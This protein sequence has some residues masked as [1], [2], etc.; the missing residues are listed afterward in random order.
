MP[1]VYTYQLLAEQQLPFKK[2]DKKCR[3]F[4]YSI[5]CV[6]IKLTLRHACGKGGKL[7][8]TERS[9]VANLGT[10]W[11]QI[12]PTTSG[13]TSAVKK[14]LAQTES[15]MTSSGSRMSGAFSSLGHKAGA[16]L[17]AGLV[18]SA[19]AATA[20]TV[21]IVKTAVSE[22]ANY[23]Q[24]VGGVETLFKESAPRLM[25][26]AEDSFKS[27][28]I[29]AN[30]YMET[31]T[32]FSASLIQSL[33]GDTEKAADYAD[34]AIVDMADN[35]NKMGSSL[36]SIQ[37]AYQGF[38]KQNYT[39]LDNLKLGY[40]GTKTE[41]E[42]L[43]ADA[44]K[45]SGVHYE[46]G[47]FADMVS[48][49]H[50]VQENLGIAGTSAKEAS[51]TITGSINSMKAAWKNL[52]VG[53]ADGNQDIGALMDNFV[54]TFKVASSNLAP[55][56]VQALS[57]AGKLV[58]SLAPVIAEQLPTLIDQ[59]LPSLIDAT[60]TLFAAL[61]E[62]LP[63][64]I[65]VLAEGFVRS[66]PKIF[67]AIISTLPKLV[68]AIGKFL[69]E[70]QNV[71]ILAASLGLLFGRSLLK[72]FSG[73]LLGIVKN[74]FK[75]IFNK[76]ITAETTSGLTKNLSSSLS[77][78]GKALAGFF[79]ALAD[80]AIA[81]G[82]AMFALAAASIAAAIFLIGS[83]VGAIMPVLKDL[84][85]NIIMPIAQFI[86]DTVLNLIVALTDATIRLTNEAL[87]PLGEFMINSFAVIL[88]TITDMITGLT[89]GAIIPLI[90]TLSGAF[91]SIIRTVGDIINS[92]L[93]TALEGIANITRAVGEGF[94]H[95]GNAIRSALEGA[96]AVVNAFANL[97][98][99]ISD[100][101]VAIVAMATNH[102]INY[103]RG[104][105]HLFAQGGRVEGPGTATSDSIPAFLSNGEY[106]I[107]ASAAREIGYDTLDDLNASGRLGSGQTNY[108]TIN[109]YNKSPE[110]L[111]NIIS[112]KIAFNQRG[113][114]G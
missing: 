67:E 9:S 60:A 41:M 78:V 30:E 24:L 99:A 102:S 13:I 32:S 27:A 108:F 57:G 66:L 46:I 48:A 51:T 96:T 23:E 90:N 5:F 88:K 22:F 106:V 56:I 7:N 31:V 103:G 111:A 2:A 75:G 83:A 82:A 50:V 84:F 11:I 52:L 114:I 93:K 58:S 112:R 12:K 68:E 92:V 91:V 70:P 37:Y 10:A 59:V 19:T 85:D 14:E 29:S 42:R 53:M 69:S 39:M 79:K 74:G 43:L 47:N 54:E 8:L 71:A 38:A 110:E 33:G 97:I 107:R 77:N 86:A 44:E 63:T 6:I 100:A 35:M 3:Q 64:I 21:S 26:Y 45:L 49:I 105:A 113:V 1:V 17:K 80:P 25:S 34:M 4:H 18:A 36:E 16:A 89:Q 72:S 20:A 28:Q 40:G 98:E 76:A 95:M 94:E 73:N 61:V 109:G 65:T 55:R 104:Y 15:E 62:A 87:I 101:A 81:I